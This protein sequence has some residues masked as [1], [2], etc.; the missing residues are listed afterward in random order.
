ME[1]GDSGL[2]AALK[3]AEAER[4]MAAAI[5]G[6]EQAKRA[7]AAEAECEVLRQQRDTLAEA[8]MKIRDEWDGQLGTGQMLADFCRSVLASSLVVVDPSDPSLAVPHFT[9]SP[10]DRK[11]T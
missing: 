6:R 2:V 5:A 4:D 3:Q 11:A 8:I 1:T 9:P 7:E 10:N